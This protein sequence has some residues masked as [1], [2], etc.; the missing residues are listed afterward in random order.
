ML[1]TCTPQRYGNHEGAIVTTLAAGELCCQ[2]PESKA[3]VG[4]HFTEVP[5]TRY[6]SISRFK[7]VHFLVIRSVGVDWERLQIACVPMAVRC[8]TSLYLPP[9]CL[10]TTQMQANNRKCTQSA[11]RTSSWNIIDF[12]DCTSNILAWT[13]IDL[14]D[15]YTEIV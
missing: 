8:F 14:L 5:L 11:D 13:I 4:V 1:F 12:G 7:S 15:V 10:R 3:N 2:H 6:Q 9:Q